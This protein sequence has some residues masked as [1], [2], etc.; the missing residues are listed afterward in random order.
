MK[1]LITI[2]IFCLIFFIGNAQN[3]KVIRENV[4][5]VKPIYAFQ[6]ESGNWI[7]VDPSYTFVHINIQDFSPIGNLVT[8]WIEQKG[9]KFNEHFVKDVLVTSD[10]IDN[11]LVYGIA[12]N[13]FCYL[14]MTEDKKEA[15]WMVSFQ[16]KE[17]K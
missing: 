8:Y 7:S 10:K 12:S 4:E 14:F 17:C 1:K 13:N 3:I 16:L 2:V 6:N 15:A 9:K 11:C 5:I